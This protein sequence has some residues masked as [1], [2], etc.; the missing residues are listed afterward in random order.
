MRRAQEDFIDARE[1]CLI[2]W[3]L[4]DRTLSE[5]ENL[6]TCLKEIVSGNHG[7]CDCGKQDSICKPHMR[8]AE[9]YLKLLMVLIGA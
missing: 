5:L 1:V 4:R 3:E 8:D 2:E 9:Q 7:V 6:C